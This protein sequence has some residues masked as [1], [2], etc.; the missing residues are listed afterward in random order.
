M[1]AKKLVGLRRAIRS[2]IR[3]MSDTFPPYTWTARS[4]EPLDD[5]EAAELHSGV[6]HDDEDE[7]DTSR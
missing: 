5:E 6:F 1:E 2:I 3:E 4:V 7:A